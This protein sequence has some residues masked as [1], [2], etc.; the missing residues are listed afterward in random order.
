MNEITKKL[1]SLAQDN[2]KIKTKKWWAIFPDYRD[3]SEGY[4][5]EKPWGGGSNMTSDFE[6]VH[7]YRYEF[8]VAQ[9]DQLI[10]ALKV[11]SEALERICSH[12]CKCGE[13]RACEAREA[14]AE[15]LRLL[16]GGAE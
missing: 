5:Q 9:R 12:G 13:C 3:L 7:A 1:D 8:V 4:L 16:N 11:A 10:A 14:Q 6:V 2:D 15:I